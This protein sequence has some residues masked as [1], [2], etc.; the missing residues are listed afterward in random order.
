MRRSLWQD[1]NTISDQVKGA[2]VVMRDFNCLLNPE[3]KV[4]SGVNMAE[5]RQSVA[6]Y[7]I[8]DLRSTGEYYTW[9]NKQGPNNRVL[10]KLD[11][12]LVNS[13][14]HVELPTSQ[15]HFIHDGLSDHCPAII[16]L[17][18]MKNKR[19]VSLN[20]IICGVYHLHLKTKL[21]DV[22]HCT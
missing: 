13:E 17:E 21:I 22:G 4:G 20:T 10:S 19:K 12:V 3:H 15:V 7:S 1:L 11:Q 6:Y 14:W 8:K 9:T 18:G 5:F 16:S 2:W